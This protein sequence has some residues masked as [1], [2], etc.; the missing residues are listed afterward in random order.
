MVE[1]VGREYNRGLSADEA[2]DALYE[3]RHHEISSSLDGASRLNDWILSGPGIVS[4]LRYSAELF[5]NASDA[6]GA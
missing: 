1:A 4:G 2:R 5:S 6:V 3:A